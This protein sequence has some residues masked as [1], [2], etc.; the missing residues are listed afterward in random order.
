[1]EISC[2]PAKRAKTLSERGLDFLDA[3]EVFAGKKATFDDDR[4]AYGEPRKIT[5]GYLRGRFVML[6]WTPRGPAVHM[7]S[8][9]YGHANE[10]KRYLAHMG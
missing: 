9:R 3:P 6:V 4:F 1:M 10:E 7:I 5:A 8:M 2:D